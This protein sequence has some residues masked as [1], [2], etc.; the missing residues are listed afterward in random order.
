M[1]LRRLG[2]E[3]L[4]YARGEM[5]E[6]LGD[7]S[8]GTRHRSASAHLALSA[9]NSCNYTVRLSDYPRGSLA[10]FLGALPLDETRIG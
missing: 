1:A 8:T 6:R 2:R 10:A 7:L 4:Q 9:L 3:I 5:Q